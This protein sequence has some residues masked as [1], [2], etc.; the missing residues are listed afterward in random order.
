M[1]QAGYCGV[2]PGSP[3]QLND[4]A[5]FSIQAMTFKTRT[6][7]V[8]LRL[9]DGARNKL[10]DVPNMPGHAP[11]AGEKRWNFLGAC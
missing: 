10:P 6:N 2:N 3:A 11:H 7:A 9:P 1:L 8:C 5:A 4:A